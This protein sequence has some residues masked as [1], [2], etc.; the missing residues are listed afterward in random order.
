MSQRLDWRLKKL[1][2]EH[3][4]AIR[5][6]VGVRLVIHGLKTDREPASS[7]PV[8]PPNSD[9]NPPTAPT[10]VEPQET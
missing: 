7:N 4:A 10:P 5:R 9:P 6:K 2:E 3:R 1:E 8:D